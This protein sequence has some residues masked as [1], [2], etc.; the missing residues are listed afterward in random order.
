MILYSEFG[1]LGML[2]YKINSSLPD[3]LEPTN[4]LVSSLT[5]NCCGGEDDFPTSA[6]A[7]GSFS[8]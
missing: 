1:T 8:N 7:K 6:A 3:I 5:I 2:G 4:S